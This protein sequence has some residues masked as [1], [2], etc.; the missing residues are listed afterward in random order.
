M[1]ANSVILGGLSVPA[2]KRMKPLERLRAVLSEVM[3]LPAR[4]RPAVA[5]ALWGKQGAALLAAADK[6]DKR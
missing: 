2:L 6:D 3:K 1:E 4:R 5:R